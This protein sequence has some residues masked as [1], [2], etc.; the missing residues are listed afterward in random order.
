MQVGNSPLLP[1]WEPAFERIGLDNLLFPSVF[2]QR[3]QFGSF[4]LQAMNERVEKSRLDKTSGHTERKDLFYWLTVAKDSDGN[5][6]YSKPEMLLEARLLMTAGSDTSSITLAAAF[7]YLSRNLKALTKLQNELRSTFDSFYIIHQGP[8]LNR[9]TYLRAVIDETLRMAPPVSSS[10]PREVEAGGIRIN[11]QYIPEGT[12][13]GTSA[14]CLHRN[15][16]NFPD[17]SIYRPERWIVNEQNGVTADD[18]AAAKLAFVPFS[19][20]SR[21][22]VGKPM[23]Y[24]EILIAL[25]RV[26]WRF[27]VRL[28]QGDRTG[29]G[30]DGEF[31]LSDV[32]VME[33]DGPWVEFRAA[34]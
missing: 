17:P 26:F 12:I 1:V 22:C 33:R 32:F 14:Y 24:A 29:E 13:L 34:R 28:K 8:K 31:E 9:C 27:D 2:T 23:A 30:A 16:D 6:G 7:F 18:V 15:I 20:G 21:G 11:N 4:V 19:L 25:A 5:P 3:A 10:I